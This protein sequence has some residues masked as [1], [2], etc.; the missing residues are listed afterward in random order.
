M[1]VHQV[2]LINWYLNERPTAVT[3]F[4]SI[5]NWTED[6]RDVP[7]TVQAVFEY[8]DKVNYVYDAT[9]ANSF[10]GEMDLIYGAFGALMMRKMTGTVSGK[11]GEPPQGDKAWIFKEANADNFSWEIYASKEQFQATS[12]IVLSA[13]ATKSVKKTEVVSPNA[14][15]EDSA[16]NSACKAFMKNCDM[17]RNGAKSFFEFYGGTTKDTEFLAN[18]VEVWSKRPKDLRAAGWQEGFE[19]T[20]CALKANEAILKGQ[21]IA[22]TKDLFDI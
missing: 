22:L 16:L 11:S 14:V 4:G 7:D 15:Y 8:P 10:E 17:M 9:L 3:G 19:A 5:L 2:D 6:G 13:D 20:V 21:K 12:G 18:M 1:G